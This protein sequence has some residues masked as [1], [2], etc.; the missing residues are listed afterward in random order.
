MSRPARK[1]VE[2][3]LNMIVLIVIVLIVAAVIIYLVVKNSNNANS[4]LSNCAA[5]GGR[6]DTQCQSG[7]TGSTFFSGGCQEG[8]ICCIKPLASTSGN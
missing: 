1:G 8:E 7:E 6:C 3:S 5:K 4:D 2:M